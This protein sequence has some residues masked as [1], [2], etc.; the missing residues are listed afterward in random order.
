[1]LKIFTAV[2]LSYVALGAA[3]PQ[4][5]CYDNM[6]QMFSS[7]YEAQ[8]LVV[9]KEFHN[10]QEMY[11]QSQKAAYSALQNC[12]N[13]ADYD[14]NVMYNFIQASEDGLSSLYGDFQQ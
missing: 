14:F 10:A 9:K 5:R 12:E 11:Q 4:S 3:Q 1:M 13:E 6:T 2:I 7:Y 8:R